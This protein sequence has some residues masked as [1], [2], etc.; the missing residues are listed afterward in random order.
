MRAYSVQ[1]KMH[2]ADE[3]KMISVLAD[4]AADAYDRAVFESIPK[5]ESE[6]PY[7]AWV[8]SV[9]YNNGNYKLFNTFEGKPY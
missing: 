5:R 7:S 2:S 3:T 1:Y 6:H 8:F 9:T 4:N